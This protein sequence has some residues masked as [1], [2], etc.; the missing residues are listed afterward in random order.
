MRDADL[1]GLQAVL[2]DD[3]LLCREDEPDSLVVDGGLLVIGVIVTNQSLLSR[4]LL[5]LFLV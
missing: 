5:L 1:S 3:V 2:V 4:R